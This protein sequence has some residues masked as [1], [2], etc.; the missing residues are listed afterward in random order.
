MEKLNKNVTTFDKISVTEDILETAGKIF[1][2]L[3]YCPPKLLELYRKLFKEESL[4]EIIVATSSMLKTSRNA[5]NK[6]TMTI[7]NK[8][9][10]YFE[11]K[12]R[13]ID[14]IER[15]SA[16]Q[17]ESKNLFTKCLENNDNKD[18]CNQALNELGKRYLNIV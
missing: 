12:S 5:E 13:F 18:N 4:R 14:S 7:W 9:I 2:Y 8:I 17:N 1:T 10:E 15:Y 11:M 6:S 16:N 3:N